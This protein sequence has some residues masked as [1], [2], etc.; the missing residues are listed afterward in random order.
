MSVRVDL[1]CH[2]LPAL[3][4]GPRTDEETLALARALVADGVGTVAATPHRTVR[5]ATPLHEL[6]ARFDALQ[7]LL[8]AHE[9]PLQV[10]TGS[11]VAVDAL[12][13][14]PETELQALR[15]GGTGP[16]LVE[17]PQREVGGD[18]TWIVHD[19][20]KRGVPVLLAHPE[21]IPF[22]Q[23][24]YAS[25]RALVDAGAHAQVTAGAF[26]G[27]YGRT[28][29]QAALDMLDGGLVD[30]IASDA[31]HAD[32]RPPE[33]ESARRWLAEHRPSAAFDDLAVHTP[34]VLIPRPAPTL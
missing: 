4:D 2:L 14:M 33:L 15:L 7:R 26:T 3:D 1:H 23:A 16:L 11:E 29:Q 31:H 32:L 24:D 10:L 34:A 9:V 5:F 20:L 18:P 21:R 13:D 30:V 8:A 19:L 28:A 22:F 6:T 27:R 12:L 17:L 25:L